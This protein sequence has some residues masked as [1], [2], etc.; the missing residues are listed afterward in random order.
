MIVN[1]ERDI[2]SSKKV[3][4]TT[5]QQPNED[6]PPS[7]TEI[8]LDKQDGIKALGVSWNPLSDSIEEDK[9]LHEEISLVEHCSNIRSTWIGDSSHDKG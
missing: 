2:D 3:Q 4:P 6:A 8:N 9:P 5:A 1:K 7:S